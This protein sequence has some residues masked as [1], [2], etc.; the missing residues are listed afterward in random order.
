M[1]EDSAEATSSPTTVLALVKEPLATFR[2]L[3]LGGPPVDTIVFPPLLAEEVLLV[4]LEATAE[5]VMVVIPVVGGN[6]PL[7]LS[8]VVGL[9]IYPG[10]EIP[11][12]PVYS[13]SRAVRGRCAVGGA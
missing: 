7:A 8:V 5:V 11:S 4:F 6:L 9:A 10:D 12:L 2:L 1:R 3:V 13:G